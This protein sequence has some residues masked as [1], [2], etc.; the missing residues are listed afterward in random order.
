M[1][2]N[3]KL[4]RSK[5]ELAATGKFS[6]KLQEQSLLSELDLTATNSKTVLEPRLSAEFVRALSR[7]PAEAIEAAFRG[8]RDVSAFFPAISDIRQLCEHWVR[9]QAEIQADQEKQAQREQV[10]QARSAGELVDFGEIKQ[11]LAEIA[12]KAEMPE[13]RLIRFSA[14]VTTR[15]IPPALPLTKEQIEARRAAEREEIE[16]YKAQGE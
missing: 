16:R 2:S 1:E 12:A 3:D 4:V 8:W 14:A 11:R 15:E 13:S 6:L 7:Y 9:R 10:E 5:Q